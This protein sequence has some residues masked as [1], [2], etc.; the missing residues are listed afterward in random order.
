M[1]QAIAVFTLADWHEQIIVAAA[2]E[3]RARLVCDCVALASAIQAVHAS[4]SLLAAVVL[5][6]V[7]DAFAWSE[8]A[9]DARVD[10]T[11]RASVLHEGQPD[12]RFRRSAKAFACR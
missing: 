6:P 9:C 8:R 7:A 4:A 10:R 3:G 11:W 1:Q 2:D 5:G 12:A